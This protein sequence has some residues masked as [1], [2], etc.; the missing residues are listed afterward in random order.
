MAV[1]R[2]WLRPSGRRIAPLDDPA[3]VLRIGNRPLA[4]WTAEALADAG[5]H[6]TEDRAA[7]CLELP[8][9]VF[10]NGL[11]LRALVEGA[12]EGNGVLVLA[13]SVF[14]DQSAALQPDTERCAAGL[15]F[16]QLR[17][18]VD[19]DGPFPDVVV[20]PEEEL[21]TVVRPASM[22][23]DLRVPLARRPCIAIGHWM[24]LLAADRAAAALPLRT[25][26]PW[27]LGLGL[28]WAVLRA[29]S[30]NKWR[31]L[32]QMGRRGPGCDVHPT[33]VVEGS[34]L[35]RGVTV[36]PHARVMF[37]NVADGASIMG[38]AV[39]EGASIGAGALVGQGSV[40]RFCVVYPGAAACMPIIQMSV[41]GRDVATTQATWA[42]DANFDN[43]VK[44]VMDGQVADSGTPFLGCAVGHGAR[45]GTGLWL[46]A[47]RDIPGGAFL[48]RHPD[49]TVRGVGDLGD[50]GPLVAVRG[51][52][53]PLAALSRSAPSADPQPAAAALHSGDRPRPESPVQ[54]VVL[55]FLPPSAPDPGA[56]AAAADALADELAAAGIGALVLGDVADSRRALRTQGGLR[57]LAGVGALPA[58]LTETAAHQPRTVRVVTATREGLL[59]AI[60]GALAVDV[61]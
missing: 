58:E 60:W 18:V 59:A 7:P 16:R 61:V 55:V 53:Q 6:R 44:V 15:R 51:K 30:L 41:L 25:T 31:V 27:R 48:I 46:A 57:V 28:L 2:A 29:R 26:A 20:D 37:S 24:H 54:P 4:E 32:A 34:V 19:P 39:V 22:G 33:A 14:V 8:D 11:L 40:V 35:G 43:N 49:Q 13:D 1:V 3:P 36:G 45:I 56:P 5:L 50:G 38:K 47:G 17:V 9:N 42:M 10:V 12:G 21:Q 23:G 52:L